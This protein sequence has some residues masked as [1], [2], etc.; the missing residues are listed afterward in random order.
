M[1]FTF[2]FRDT[3]TLEQ[4]RDYVVP[5]IRTRRFFR[6]WDAGCAMGPEP[7]TLAIILREN[8]GAMIFRNVQIDATDIDGSN[9]FAKII[10][11]GIYPW[12]QL[13]RI[14]TDIFERYFEKTDNPDQ[15]R[16]IEEMRKRIT[17]TRHDLTQ[18]QPLRRDYGLIICKNVLLHF[19][20]EMRIKVM[21]MYHDSLEPGGYFLT[22][23]TQKLPACLEDRFERVV[24]NA[25]IFRKK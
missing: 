25:Q 17:F 5:I 1:A 24:P 21:E 10:E 12:E 6:I 11:D 13:G 15:F 20:E 22:E 14:P 23:Q 18:L 9:Q 8:M 3:Q 16:I 7:Y 2:F 4:V 19:T